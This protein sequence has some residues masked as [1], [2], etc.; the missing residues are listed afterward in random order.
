MATSQTRQTKPKKTLSEDEYKDWEDKL[1][2][3]ISIHEKDVAAPLKRYRNFYNGKQWDEDDGSKDLFNDEVVDNMVFSVIN[4]IKPSIDITKP[5]IFVKPRKSSFIVEGGER[6]EGSVGAARVQVL[7]EFLYSEL[8]VEREV[9]K[10]RVDSLLGHRGIIFVG[11]DV[12]TRT[13]ERDDDIGES[14]PFLELI[15]SE[16]IFVKRISEMDIIS[17]PFSIE[18]DFEDGDWIAIRWVELL[19]DLKD[20]PNLK[21]TTDLVAN[22]MMEHDARSD[23]DRVFTRFKREAGGDNVAKKAS[24][25]DAVEGWDVW[26]KKNQKFI[27]IVLDHNK[28]LQF[29]DWPINYGNRFPT[30]VLFYNYNPDRSVPLSDTK[31]YIVKQEFLN[32]FESKLLDSVKR[33]ADIKFAFNK[34]KTTQQKVDR[35]A[36]APS[37]VAIGLNGPPADAIMK[38]DSTAV[39][40]DLYRTIQLIKQDI[41][42]QLGI[43]QF[44]QG[45]ADKL[46]TADEGRRIGQAT[47]QRRENRSET[48]RDF[49][50]RVMGKL[51]LVAQQVLP[52]G[53]EIPLSEGQFAG[54]QQNAPETLAR[55]DTGRVDQG[56]RVMEILPFM[57]VDRNLIGG[58]YSFK[59]EVGSTAPTNEHTE[60]EDAT[61]LFELASSN[62]LINKVEATRIILEKS[63]FGEYIDRLLRDPQEVA[64]ESQQ[65]SQAAQEAALAEPRLKTSTDLEKTKMKSATAIET[66]QIKSGDQTRGELIEQIEGDKNRRVD[67]MKA[68]IA[69]R[70]QKREAS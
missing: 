8:R 39:A 43:A 61:N 15:E 10:C 67:L 11:F 46:E 66:A 47:A 21:N 31:T 6:V 22:G 40:A 30:E 20:N 70:D 41:F 1:E 54:L 23:R 13:I 53:E 9:D 5:R 38:I 18:H 36:K 24:I 4:T 12:K 29:K 35:W 58:K 50:A 51:L 28:P 14:D 49:I 26:D 55:R 62:P 60:R 34:K 44:E 19:Q 56:G 42:T 25:H 16:N 68:L 52:E 32:K 33:I 57:K 17:D 37:G 65:A 59:I 69:K 63:G 27:K 48:V 3:A 2:T 7:S 45:G 64:R